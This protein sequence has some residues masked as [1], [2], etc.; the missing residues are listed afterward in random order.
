MPLIDEYTGASVGI[1]YIHY[2]TH[3]GKMYYWNYKFTSI[4]AATGAFVYVTI[5]AGV[6]LHYSAE[7]FSSSGGV[8]DAYYSPTVSANGTEIAAKNYDGTITKPTKAKA[9]VTPTVSANGTAFRYI[10]IGGGTT[11]AGNSSTGHGEQRLEL[12]VGPGTYLLNIKPLADT[13]TIIFDIA[14]YEEEE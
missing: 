9:Y 11:V 6:K 8:L 2:K 1:D 12:L 10:G 3:N 5:P 4:A 7:Y 14:F 13:S